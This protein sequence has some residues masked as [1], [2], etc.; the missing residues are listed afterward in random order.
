MT[1][2]SSILITIFIIISL[3]FKSGAAYC[4]IKSAS[5][6]YYKNIIPG[7][8]SAEQAFTILGNAPKTRVNDDN[9]ISHIY[10]T[11]KAGYPDE[12]TVKNGQIVHMA[13]TI[14]DTSEL[15]IKDV[16][17]ALGEAARKGYS[18]YAFTLRVAAYPEKGMV[19][20]YEENSGA[21]IEKQF[22]I[23]CTPDEFE[24]T[25][26]KNFPEKYPYKM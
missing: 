24:K 8:T 9:T 17:A 10:E 3:F 21:V 22:F 15:N 11:K 13:V 12:I 18:F 6:F 5:K 23:P 4:E 1:A 26:G 19:F 14:E 7:K 2:K 20:I 16:T 25:F